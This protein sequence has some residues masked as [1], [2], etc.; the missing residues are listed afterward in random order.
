M[1][2][3]FAVLAI[4]SKNPF[5]IRLMVIF[6]VKIPTVIKNVFHSR[7]MGQVF[8]GDGDNP[9]GRTPAPLI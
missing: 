9:E 5:V 1:H 6:F 2:R 4:Q 3:K 8:Q 7:K